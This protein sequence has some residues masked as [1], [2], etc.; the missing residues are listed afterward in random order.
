ML[1]RLTLVAMFGLF[2]APA[3][4]QTANPPAFVGAPVTGTVKAV[5]SDRVVLSTAK[6]DVDVP[7]TPETRVLT[8]E[9]A[10]ASEIK[11]GGYVGTANVTNAAGGTATEVHMMDNGPNVHFPMNEA[12][13]LMMTNGHVKSVQITPKGQEMDVDYGAGIRHVVVPP[14]TPVTRMI[15]S[16]VASLRIG[17]AVTA[18]FRAAADGKSTAAYIVVDPP[19]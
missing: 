11:P 6:G 13:G 3:S 10:A 4:A 14:A 8:R 1:T 16:D 7:L 18:R 17:E 9:E 19:K 5:N 15:A 2:T 12:P